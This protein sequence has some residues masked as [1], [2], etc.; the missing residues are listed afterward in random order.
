MVW[1]PAAIRGLLSAILLPLSAFRVLLSAIPLPLSAFS[2]PLS[3]IVSIQSIKKPLL[4]F[5][6]WF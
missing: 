3:A 1:H 4:K 2:L 5:E 6:K